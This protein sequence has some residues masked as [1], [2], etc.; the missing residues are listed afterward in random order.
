MFV[1]KFKA[2]ALQLT[3]FIIVVIALLLTT[4]IL[5]IHLHKQFQIQSDFIIDTTNLANSGVDYVIQNNVKINDTIAIDLNEEDYKNLKIYRK[6]WGVFEQVIST[7]A[8]K[9]RRFQK[10]AFLGA[11]QQ[12]SNRAVLYVQDNNTPLVLVGM[13]KIEGL[14][15]LP[16]QGVKSGYISGQSYY[17]SRLI[18][19]GTRV[20][21]KLPK[22]SSDVVNSISQLEQSYSKLPLNQF[23]NIQES[24]TFTNSFLQPLQ[25]VF[26]N[27]EINLRNIQIIGHVLLQSKSKIVVHSS[28]NL[29][30]VILMAPEIELRSNTK[31]SF[32]AIASKKIV[33]G[34][35]VKLNY[36]SALVVKE[37]NGSQKETSTS[38]SRDEVSKV[39]VEKDAVIKGVIMFIGEDRPN[40]YQ[41]QI[42]IKESATVYGE[43]Y[44]TQNTELQ[45][46]VYG[47]IFT[48][49]F[50]A[51]QSGAVYKNHIYNG[52]INVNELP[53]EYVGLLFNDSKKGIMKWLY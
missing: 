21:S 44:N 15:Y 45:G 17:G 2:G 34:D 35:N 16:K 20:S 25:I 50:I 9:N 48:S 14:A 26:S 40:N 42:L 29:K 41:S 27:D 32:Q 33:V 6:F 43:L 28:S 13:T 39:V 23:F 3:T 4:F 10:V 22:L 1:L 7:A 51:N 11:K 36:P 8:I 52:K 53:R 49:N 31:G 47:S 38:V 5:L 37:K 24:T 18:Y 30:D 46:A 12:K 19:G